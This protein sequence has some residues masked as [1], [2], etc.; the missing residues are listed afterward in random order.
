MGGITNTEIT[1]QCDFVA[2]EM[3]I[4]LPWV[5][6]HVDQKAGKPCPKCGGSGRWNGGFRSGSCFRCS[7]GGGKATPEA[8]QAALQWVQENAVKVMKLGAKRDSNRAKKADVK[9]QAAQDQLTARNKGD[10]DRFDA[11]VAANPRHA[12]ALENMKEGEFKSSL[13]EAAR[14]GWMTDG[15][16]GALWKEAAKQENICRG[17][18]KP[19]PEKGTEGDFLVTITE[20]KFEHINNF[21][22]LCTSMEFKSPDGW[23]GRLETRSTKIEAFLKSRTSDEVLVTGRV[24]WNRDDYAI[25]GGR[26]KV[27]SR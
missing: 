23:R 27:S 12:W 17:E 13:T 20:V 25:I 26:V 19:A 3:S 5:R 16:M 1:R 14:R 9:A 2:V 24:R 18:T 6:H 11:W 4:P 22:E 15:R 8:V 10:E 21:D 7:G